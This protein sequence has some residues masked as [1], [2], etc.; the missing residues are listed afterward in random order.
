MKVQAIVY[1]SMTGYTAQYAALLSK[2][3][4]L[5]AYTLQEAEKKI[6]AKMPVLFMS[7]LMAGTLTDYKKAKKHLN[8]I[9]CC[10][11]GLNATSEQ[12]QAT[13]KNTGIA[14]SVPLFPLPGGYN[15][16]KLKG[17][18]KWAMK[19]VTSVLIK[20]I[21]AKADKRE[22]DESMLY[23]LQHGGSFVHEENLLPAIAYLQ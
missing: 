23:T 3:T 14:D 8:I 10:S 9:A 1:T 6:P 4:G 2:K 7:W 21:S 20:K 22:E 13:K 16:N 15:P 12:A 18:Y 19:M 5:P 11:V 17:P